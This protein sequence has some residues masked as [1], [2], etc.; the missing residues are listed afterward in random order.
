MQRSQGGTG[1]QEGPLVGVQVPLRDCS[2]GAMGTLWPPK[3]TL[4][5]QVCAFGITATSRELELHLSVL[6]TTHAFKKSNQKTWEAF[7]AMQSGAG[8]V[9]ASLCSGMK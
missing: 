5:S 6:E 7:R 3:L 2:L 8:L 9:D 1:R 4:C